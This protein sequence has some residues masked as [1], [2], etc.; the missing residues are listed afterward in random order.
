M[1]VYFTHGAKGVEEGKKHLKELK[2]LIA[3]Y[4]ENNSQTPLRLPDFMMVI[5][6][7]GMAYQDGEVFVVPLEVLKN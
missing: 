3:R 2:E 7:T 4:N 1:I 6:A 5:T